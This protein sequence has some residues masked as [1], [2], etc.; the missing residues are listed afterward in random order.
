[1]WYS[2]I[3]PAG[4]LARVIYEVDLTSAGKRPLPSTGHGHRTEQSVHALLLAH[5]F[6]VRDRRRLRCNKAGI[7]DISV[8]IVVVGSVSKC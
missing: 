7:A 4:G 3:L 8:V 2:R 5:S 1:M 6:E